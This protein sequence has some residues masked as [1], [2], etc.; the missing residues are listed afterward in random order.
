MPPDRA[1]DLDKQGGTCKTSLHSAE[2]LCEGVG[3]R[4]G[5][6]VERELGQALDKTQQQSDWSGALT[7]SQLAYAAHD[8]DVLVPLLEALK[9]RLTAAN[10]DR[11][12]DIETRCLPAL[13]WISS[14]GVPFNR[15][16]WQQLVDQA[17][18]DVARLC[19]ALDNVAPVAPEM[20]ITTWN[21][22]SPV[23]VKKVLA[24]VG[25]TVEST[26]DD[27]RAKPGL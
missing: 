14:K 15:D 8:V 16:R 24:L 17:E 27:A 13:V 3:H 11:V 19:V 2:Q 12:A 6:C 18:A 23:E 10:L 5:D 26:G 20:L 4:L 1:T 22:D 7:P 9:K 25:H 21:W